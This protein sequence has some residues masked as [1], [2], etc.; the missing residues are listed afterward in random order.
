[1][2]NYNSKENENPLIGILYHQ[3]LHVCTH[4][5]LFFQCPIYQ[6]LAQASTGKTKSDVRRAKS[7]ENEQKTRCQTKIFL[8]KVLFAESFF[9]LTFGHHSI[10]QTII[11]IFILEINTLP[12]GDILLARP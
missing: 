4:R 12:T 2:E 6:F 8:G 10:G 7:D 5:P 9:L 11:F 1:M 3:S